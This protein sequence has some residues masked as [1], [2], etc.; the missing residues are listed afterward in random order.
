MRPAVNTDIKSLRPY[1][2]S[3]TR[4][5]SGLPRP[6]V[7]GTS[8]TQQVYVSKPATVSAL[9]RADGTRPPKAWTNSWFR[10]PEVVRDVSFDYGTT[11]F[12]D[13]YTGSVTCLP[14]TRLSLVKM[15]APWAAGGSYSFPY[16]VEAAAR[17]RF[18]NELQD[19]KM[20]LGVMLGEMRET[21]HGLHL[22]ASG[23]LSGLEDVING[24]RQ[25]RRATLAFLLG[26]GNIKRAQ[27]IIRSD[28][29]GWRGKLRAR[30]ALLREV[31]VFGTPAGRK[32]AS[33]IISTWMGVQFG[34]KPLLY[35]IH[36]SATAL[37]DYVNGPHPKAAKLTVRKGASDKWIG[38]VTFDG[39]FAPFPKTDFDVYAYTGCFIA[40]TYEVPVS[41]G[42]TIEQLGLGNPA[43]IAW[44]LVQ[45]SWMVDYVLQV[46]PWLNSLT[47]ARDCTFVEGTISYLQKATTLRSGVVKPYSSAMTLL[48]GSGPMGITVEGGRFVRTVVNKPG[49]FP[50]Y[51]PAVHTRLGLSQLANITGFLATKLG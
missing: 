24:S 2:M 5:S 46:G 41:R 3:V 10:C 47:A 17:T 43:V 32:T 34:L 15:H 42:R 8:T 1:S 12:R 20:Q 18:L 31:E 51:R 22:L 14:V 29:Y 37:D 35:D 36:D 26:G 16:D 49:I 44:E 38:R 11:P 23:L 13:R 40:A 4:L 30:E 33:R 7:V 6:S 9:F 25:S 48:R 27:H 21:V 39:P 50:A 19:G 45:A 28:K